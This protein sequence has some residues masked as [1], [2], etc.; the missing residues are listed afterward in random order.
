MGMEGKFIGHGIVVACPVLIFL[1]PLSISEFV[2]KSGTLASIWRERR[3]F[4]QK[5]FETG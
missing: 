5:R 4:P 2:M 1:P 3:G